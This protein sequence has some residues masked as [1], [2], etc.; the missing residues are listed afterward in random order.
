MTLAVGLDDQPTLE[1]DAEMS[2]GPDDCQKRKKGD[3]FLVRKIN[4]M[5]R[6]GVR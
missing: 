4:I 6:D 2:S 3:T 5:R 1:F